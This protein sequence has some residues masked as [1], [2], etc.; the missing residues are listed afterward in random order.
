MRLA[1]VTA[2]S[3]MR[4]SLTKAMTELM[5]SVMNWIWP[6]ARSTSAGALP[7]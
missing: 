2:S 3:F 6:A 7:R 5:V 4:L 1:V